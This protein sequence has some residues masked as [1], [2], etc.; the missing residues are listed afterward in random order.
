MIRTLLG[1]FDRSLP[2]TIW[3]YTALPPGRL[4][5]ALVMLASFVVL[6]EFTRIALASEHTRSRIA[7]LTMGLLTFPLQSIALAV[8]LVHAAIAYPSR[9]W[10]NLVLV[11]GLYGVWYLAGEATRLVRPSREGADIGFMTVGGLITFS[12]GLVAALVAR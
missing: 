4:L 6:C 9:A 12:V 8:V 11:L 2:E 5:P 1:G 3:T 10:F 7:H